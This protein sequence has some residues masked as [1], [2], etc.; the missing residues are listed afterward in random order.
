MIMRTSNPVPADLLQAVLACA[1]DLD[2]PRGHCPT[3]DQY[4]F[5]QMSGNDEPIEWDSPYDPSKTR[6]LSSALVHFAGSW[7]K[8]AAQA[9]MTI[10]GGVDLRDELEAEAKVEAERMEAFVAARR[11][12]ER[13]LDEAAKTVSTEPF[14]GGVPISV[15]MTAF[16]TMYIKASSVEEGHELLMNIGLNED[17]WM[18]SIDGIMHTEIEP[19]DRQGNR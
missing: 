19:L 16:G 8:V 4:D 10:V 13:R 11:E 12:Q 5:W 9:H 14:E 6:P 7:P 17:L 1:A 2:L 15:S 18:K 3:Q